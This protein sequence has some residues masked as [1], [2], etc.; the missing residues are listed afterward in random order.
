MFTDATIERIGKYTSFTTSTNAYLEALRNDELLSDE[1][2]Y[3]DFKIRI[4]FYN[5]VANS[6]A[7]EAYST[8][9]KICERVANKKFKL[10]N[11]NDASVTISLGVS[12]FPNDGE[13]AEQLIENADKRLYDA[14]N[15]GRNQVK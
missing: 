15:S 10:A 7:D 14:K 13:S 5:E 6:N 11:G 4:K 8:A 12:T 1:A 9:Q 3:E 2:Y